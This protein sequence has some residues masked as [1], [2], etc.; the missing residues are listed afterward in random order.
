[1]VDIKHLEDCCGCT[2]CANICPH[3]AI[4]MK[5]DA[6][7]FKYPKVDKLK[8]TECGLCEK[9]CAFNDNYDTA[10]NIKPLV[11]GAR[12]KNIDEV[13]ASRSG[14]AFV[15]ISDYVLNHGGVVYGAGYDENFRVVHKRA[16]N[17]QQRDEFR[18]SKYVQSD[19]DGIFRQV[20]D[21]LRDGLIVLFTGTPCQTSG[22]NSFIGSKLRKN[23]ILVDIICHGVPGPYI[24]RDYLVYLE[25]KRG[26]KIVNVNFRDKK[27]Y[28]WSAHVESVLY[29]GDT[30]YT[31]Y[32]SYTSTFYQHIMFRESC[33]NCKFCNTIRPSD[34]TLADFWGWQKSNPKFNADDKGANLILVNTENGRNIWCIV[35]EN[36]NTFEVELE[37]CLQPNLKKPSFKNEKYDSFVSDYQHNGIEYVLKWYSPSLLSKFKTLL[38]LCLGGKIINSIRNCKWKLASLLNM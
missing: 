4:E 38:I 28:G 22:L 37:N 1:M 14:G 27:R 33:Y 20:R 7:G 15:A 21:D 24:W 34:I 13:M 25:R 35:K 30:S 6:L 2:A 3:G 18:G 10:L 31:S 12:H 36:M 19:L 32:T 9:V 8:C 23:L 5:P 17:K 11:F 29:E 26:K 16:V